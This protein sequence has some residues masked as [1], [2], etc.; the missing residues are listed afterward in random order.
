MVSKLDAKHLKAIEQLIK[1][2][3]NWFGDM[4][5]EES[6]VEAREE[7]PK[8]PSSRQAAKPERQPK[9]EREPKPERQAAKPEREHKPERER[10][11]QTVKPPRPHRPEPRH[12]PDAP[13]T[14]G[15]HSGNM[16]AFLARPVRSA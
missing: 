7:R 5:K 3:I 16:P 8:R 11:P 13:D 14:G 15:F 9:P 4:P 10:A 6:A 12:L 1:K 2:E